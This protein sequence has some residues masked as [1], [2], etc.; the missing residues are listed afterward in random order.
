[1]TDPD[2]ALEI[3]FSSKEKAG[4]HQQPR[5]NTPPVLDH[6][7]QAVLDPLEKP[8]YCLGVTLA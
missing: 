6:H 8:G 5:A 2:L 4:P 1:M 3:S 7:L